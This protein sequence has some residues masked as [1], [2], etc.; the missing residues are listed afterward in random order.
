MDGRYPVPRLT[1]KREDEEGI[2]LEKRILEAASELA[3]FQ[4]LP[5]FTVVTNRFRQIVWANREALRMLGADSIRNLAGKRPGEVF[6]C[7]HAE[8]P[9]GGCGITEFCAFCGAAGSLAS[10]L[11]GVEGGE[12]CVIRRGERHDFDSLELL[13]WTRPLSLSGRDFIAFA[14]R[15]LSAQK[16]REV[17]ERVFYH[18]ILN[19]AASLLSLTSLLRDMPEPEFSE[20]LGLAENEAERLVDEIESQRSVKAAEDGDLVLDGEACDADE[21]LDAALKPYRHF[22]GL[23]EVELRRGPLAPGPAVRTDRAL[24]RRVVVNMVKNALEASGKGDY[25][26]ACVER[27]EDG[28]EVRIGNPSVLTEEERIRMFQRSFSTKGKGRGL[29]AYGMKLLGEGYLGGRIWF[30]SSEESGTI[31]HLFLPFVTRD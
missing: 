11:E 19:T 6:G 9:D 27:R 1:S 13:V 31:F 28:I 23:R 2:E 5:I 14:A 18:D 10:A 29:G 25:V 7:M 26:S 21:L 3:L 15:D 30:E 22:L 4:D 16:R 20:Y 17:L 24:A 12:E 8:N